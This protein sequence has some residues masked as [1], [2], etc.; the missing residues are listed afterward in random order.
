MT[1]EKA[2]KKS[3]GTWSNKLMKIWFQKSLKTSW[4]QGW[5]LVFCF[6]SLI[7]INQD[8]NNNIPDI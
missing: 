2:F 8:K 7:K 3:K 5:S 4:F 1:S 6:F